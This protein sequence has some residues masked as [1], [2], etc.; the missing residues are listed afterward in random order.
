MRCPY[1]QGLR[2][3]EV[4]RL[5]LGDLDLNAHRVRIE[6]SK[7][8]RDRLVCLSG[9][10]IA[11]LQAYLEVRGPADDHVFVFRHHPLSNTPATSGCRPTPGG[12]GC[13]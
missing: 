1:R 11:A 12:W 3:G 6:Q 10:N 4:R 7:G 13:T 5:R 9:A 8:L 2:R